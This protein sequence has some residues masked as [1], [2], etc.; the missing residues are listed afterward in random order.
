MKMRCKRTLRVRPAW[1]EFV[2]RKTH[3]KLGDP[4][5]QAAA[6]PSD[7]AQQVLDTCAELPLLTGDPAFV[8][9]Y[10]ADTVR[11]IFELDVVGMLVRDGATF[12]VDA[13]SG[14]P[15]QRLASSSLIS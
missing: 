8:R 3:R 12:L 14:P 15:E 10:V 11:T 4:R 13:V 7:L 6:H 9:G 1:S 2:S 5:R